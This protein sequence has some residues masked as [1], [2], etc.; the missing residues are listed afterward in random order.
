MVRSVL[1][2]LQLLNS[3]ID[4]LSRGEPVSHLTV[5]FFVLNAHHIKKVQVEM[6]ASGSLAPLFH[7]FGLISEEELSQQKPDSGICFCVATGR[8]ANSDT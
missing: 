8:A 6:T 4:C 2:L 1:G 3:Y 5:S 7:A